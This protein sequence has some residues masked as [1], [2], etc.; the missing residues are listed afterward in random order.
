VSEGIPFN[1]FTAWN[2]LPLFISFIL[3]FAA[4][5]KGKPLHKAYGFLLGSMLLS[6]FFHLAWLFDWWGS[7]TGSSTA[8][9]IFIFIPIYSL[10]SGAF[11]VAISKRIIDWYHRQLP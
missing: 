11:G 3:Y 7:K 4:V 1:E 2:M 5:A 8:G 6:V 9:L 10:V